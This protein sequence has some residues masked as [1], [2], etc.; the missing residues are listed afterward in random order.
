MRRVAILG[1]TGSIGS[2]A[3]EVVAAAPDRLQVSALAAGQ[4]VER[5]AEQVR[6]FQPELVSVRAPKD[7]ERLRQ[8][9]GEPGPEVLCGAEGARAVATHT[10]DVVLCAMVG[11]QGLE[12]T[13]AA[14]SRPV[15]VAVANKEPLVMAGE[16]CVARA[17]EGGATLVPVDSEHSAIF[18]VLRGRD[19]GAVRRLLLTGSG[20]PFREVGDLDQ[21]TREQA[22]AHP[23]WAMGEKITIDSATLMNKGLEVIEAHWLFGVPA[24]QIEVLIHPQSIVHSLV[25]LRDGSVLAQLGTPDMRVPIAH[26]LAHPERLELPFPSLDL[27]RVGP[28]TFEPPD[29]V[30]F[31]C[32][33]LAYAALERGESFPTV[34][35][36]A[37]EVAVAA[38]LEGKIPFSAIPKVIER[39]LGEHRSTDTALEAL[40][41]ADAWA[42]RQAGKCFGAG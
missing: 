39:T 37:N 31:P 41:E 9:L 35:N 15:I 23:T 14:L 32:L 3:L 24:R 22:L 11:A 28:L 12:P 16:L 33:G 17:L 20:G 34:L 7:R 4:N 27:T 21:V 2:A 40:L 36:A 42:R 13:L 38:F 8:L 26:A 1:S 25:E 30:R 29:T 5:L 10:A 18:Q 19:A 6:R